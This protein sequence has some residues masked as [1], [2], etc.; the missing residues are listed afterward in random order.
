MGVRALR[1]ANAIFF[2][3]GAHGYCWPS[4]SRLADLA[5]YE[6]PAEIRRGLTVLI[7]HGMLRSLKVYNLPKHL[8]EIATRPVKQ[9]GSG[10]SL[11][12]TA[13]SIVAPTEWERHEK[14]RHVPP[15]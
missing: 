7:R 3:T 6:D 13:Y 8:A 15:T 2:S 9:N 10:R 12:G 11:R 1:V 14:G 5:G 4:Q